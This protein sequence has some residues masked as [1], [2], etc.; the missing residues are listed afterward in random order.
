VALSQA[1][2]LRR[3]TED[4]AAA[5]GGRPYPGPSEGP[6]GGPAGSPGA[7]NSQGGNKPV[8]K[9]QETASSFYGVGFYG[10]GYGGFGYGPW[11]GGWGYPGGFGYGFGYPGY[12][13]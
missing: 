7:I 9:D 2:D 12:F 4:R 6:A 13:W 5:R 10:P 11:G 1:A 3:L 8:A